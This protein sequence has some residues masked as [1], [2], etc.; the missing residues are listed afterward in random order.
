M[1]YFDEPVGR[2]KIQTTSKSSQRYYTT[3]RLIRYISF[4]SPFFISLIRVTLANSCHHSRGFRSFLSFEMFHSTTYYSSV[5]YSNCFNFQMTVESNY[6]IAI[7]RPCASFSANED[8]KTK[9]KT[10]CTLYAPRFQRFEQ[11][12]GNL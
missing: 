3:K 8:K 7:A 11:I 9:T 2:V 5:M 6:A 10:N 4:C 12:T 1:P